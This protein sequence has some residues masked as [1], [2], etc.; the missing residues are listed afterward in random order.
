MKPTASQRP[1]VEHVDEHPDA[2]ERQGTKHEA[3]LIFNSQ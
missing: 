2:V 1:V 3:S